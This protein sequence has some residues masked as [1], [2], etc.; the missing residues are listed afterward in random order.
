LVAAEE[1]HVIQDLNEA[2]DQRQEIL[3]QQGEEDFR[4]IQDKEQDFAAVAAKKGGA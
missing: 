1:E 3:L 2:E 4:H